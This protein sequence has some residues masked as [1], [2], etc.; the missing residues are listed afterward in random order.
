MI[1]HCK[2]INTNEEERKMSINSPNIC[3]FN[4]EIKDYP[5]NYI[6]EPCNCF[7]VKKLNDFNR[8]FYYLISEKYYKPSKTNNFTTKLEELVY[9]KR[10][11]I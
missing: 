3:F 7:S 4:F 1:I 9:Y 10:K 2:P 8:K 11:R 5:H 6:D